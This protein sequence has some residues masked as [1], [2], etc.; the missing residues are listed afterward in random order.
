LGYAGDIVNTVQGK[1]AHIVRELTQGARDVVVK[2]AVKE[3]V[4]ISPHKTTIAPLTNS[5]KVE[6]FGPLKL[7]GKELCNR[8][9]I[10]EIQRPGVSSRC[11]NLVY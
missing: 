3:G 6:N 11:S 2:W 10:L 4:N 1:F 7:H 9:G 8:P 5:R